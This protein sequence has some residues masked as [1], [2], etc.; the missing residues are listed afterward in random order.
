MLF[1]CLCVLAQC[2]ELIGI[3]ADVD[4]AEADGW[5]PLLFSASN[6]HVNLVSILLESG[7]NVNYRALSGMV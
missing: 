4:Q 7:A 1:T 5:N 2:L 6:G 3:G